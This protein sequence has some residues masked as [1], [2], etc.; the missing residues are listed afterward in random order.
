[1][2]R[3]IEGT[4]YKD[5][6]TSLQS[7]GLGEKNHFERDILYER[8]SGG[9]AIRTNKLKDFLKY[10]PIRVGLVETE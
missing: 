8:M 2:A 10:K 3:K 1:M 5:L 6:S 7:F 9:F 4:I